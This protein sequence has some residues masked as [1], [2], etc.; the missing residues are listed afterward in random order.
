MLPCR[1]CGQNGKPSQTVLDYSD[2][3]MMPG[4]GRAVAT[5]G[6]RTVAALASKQLNP[7]F[8]NAPSEVQ[9]VHL[10]LKMFK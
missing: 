6:T 5:T 1:S 7:H 8:Q 9:L 2:L 4:I 3:G 10:C